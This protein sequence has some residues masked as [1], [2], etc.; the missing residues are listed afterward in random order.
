M[1]DETLK[2]KISNAAVD[3]VMRLGEQIK[4]GKEDVWSSKNFTHPVPIEGFVAEIEVKT[5]LRKVEK[6]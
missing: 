6:G 3:A 2:S 4:S 1:V 5:V